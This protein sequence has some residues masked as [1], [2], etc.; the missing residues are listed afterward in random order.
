MKRI[1]LLGLVLVALVRADSL[2]CRLVGN[3]GTPGKAWDLVVNGNYAYVADLDSG[4][5]VID[6]S[7]PTHPVETSHCDMPGL[8][9]GVHVVGNYAYVADFAAGL[10]VMDVSDHAHPVETG[11]FDTPGHAFGVRVIGKYA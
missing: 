8:A 2:N 6:V 5:R 9:V 1:A 10:R 11:Y 3:C 7:D 4:L